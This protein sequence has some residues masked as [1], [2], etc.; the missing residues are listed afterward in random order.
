VPQDAVTDGQHPALVLRQQ[1]VQ[2]VPVARLTGPQQGGLG[3]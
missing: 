3:R 2:R 1:L